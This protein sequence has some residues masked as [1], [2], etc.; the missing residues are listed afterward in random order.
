MELEGGNGAVA[1]GGA[2][3]ALAIVGPGPDEELVVTDVDAVLAVWFGEYPAAMMFY[4][5]KTDHQSVAMVNCPWHVAM[6]FFVSV[7]ENPGFR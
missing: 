3:G 1:G 5:W 2:I 4:L 6:V 7:L